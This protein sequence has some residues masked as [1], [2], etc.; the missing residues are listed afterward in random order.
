MKDMARLITDYNGFRFV[1][2]L[3][4]SCSVITV[5][6]GNLRGNQ[7]L[8]SQFIGLG[9]FCYSM[10]ANSLFFLSRRSSWAFCHGNKSPPG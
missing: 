6:F 9:S 4:I 7:I 8:G 1:I 3:P 2:G 10:M 5:L